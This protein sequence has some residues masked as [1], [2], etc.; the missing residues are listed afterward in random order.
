MKIAEEAIHRSLPRWTTAS[1]QR[2]GGVN[3]V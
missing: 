1:W 3:P 2:D